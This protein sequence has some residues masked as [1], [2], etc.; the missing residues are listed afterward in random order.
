[1][2]SVAVLCLPG[3]LR[4]ASGC[5]KDTRA[6]FGQTT[7][8][9]AGKKLTW[10]L[11][12]GGHGSEPPLLSPCPVPSAAHQHQSPSPP[13]LHTSSLS[14]QY[15][16]SSNW[17]PRCWGWPGGITGKWLN[18]TLANGAL[19]HTPGQ[20]PAPLFSPAQPSNHLGRAPS[21]SAYA[22][23]STAYFACPLHGVS[24]AGICLEG[25]GR[26]RA[27]ERDPG[28]GRRLALCW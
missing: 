12:S 21:S 20:P 5:H 13:P 22:L 14:P 24:C 11:F 17:F 8:I 1:M 18:T 26:R 28:A 10:P 15:C 16:H 4:G 25:W 6:E 23:L 27:A 7:G 2:P 19:P 3:G 9:V